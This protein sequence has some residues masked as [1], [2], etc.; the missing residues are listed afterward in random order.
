MKKQQT[1]TP[2][3]VLL[4]LL[5]TF[6]FLAASAQV[7]INTVTPTEMLHVNGNIRIDGD[8]R[9]GN[10]VGNTDQ[11]LVSQ[12][13]GTPPSWGPG[14]LNTAQINN[15]GK[16]FVNGIN[17]NNGIYLQLDVPDINTV[18]S[19]TIHITYPGNL[20]AGPGWGYDFTIFPEARA[21]VIR[22]H[23]IN[24]S[25][26]NITGLNVAYTAVY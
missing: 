22:F 1:L 5:L 2:Q 23:I 14:F 19:S 6:L 26:F 20:P 3:N 16:Y 25:G 7:G 24:V 11:I 9:P 8:F 18:V 21:G 13:T 12:G 15:I 10:T 17:I 4:S